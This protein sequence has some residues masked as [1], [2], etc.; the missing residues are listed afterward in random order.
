MSVR[1]T[2]DPE[3]ALASNFEESPKRAR[4][5]LWALGAHFVL[6]VFLGGIFFLGMRPGGEAPI[7]VYVKG[8][9]FLALAALLLLSFGLVQSL[10]RRPFLQSGRLRSFLFLVA[11]F[12]LVNMPVPYPSS[13][14]EHPSTVCFRLPVE[15]EWTVF[16]GGEETDENRLASFLPDRRWGLDLLYMEDR[17]MFRGA[18]D[19][20]E[21][22]FVFGQP[23]FAPAVGRVVGIVD[24]ELDGDP[25]RP[26]AGASLDGNLVVLETGENEFCFLTHLRQGSIRVQEGEE[27]VAGQLL[28]EVGTSGFSA[29][30]PVPHLALH[31]QDRSIGVGE[32]IPWHF[33]DYQANGQLVARGL[34]RGGVSEK[35][36]PVG[37]R[38]SVSAPR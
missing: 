10:L 16:W 35:G 36:H 34:P 38:I 11:V 2:R 13:H 23:V 32:A 33:C 3:V 37:Q 20:K 26:T 29:F 21:D 7:A 6:A 24:G 31:L 18:G 17:A 27:V 9:L 4:L 14:E 25:R 8:R 1:R 5:E 15:G 22:W 30:T 19:A 28:A 12:G